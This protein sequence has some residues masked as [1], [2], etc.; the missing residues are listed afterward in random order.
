MTDWAKLVMAV[1]LLSMCMAGAGPTVMGQTDYD[2][3]VA[4][5]LRTLERLKFEAQ[6]SGDSASLSAMLD[7]A[8]MLADQDGTFRTKSEY[9]AGL[10]Q[11]DAILQRISPES[12]TVIVFEQ[13]AIVVGMYQ[14]KGTDAARP[15]HRRCRFID[16]WAFKNGRWVCI[17]STATS[18]VR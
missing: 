16:T 3:N 6:Q 11:S 14:E 2:T 12:I 7:D 5:A 15:Y 10:R 18:V 17:A 4:I 13:T 8:A 1:C 9:L